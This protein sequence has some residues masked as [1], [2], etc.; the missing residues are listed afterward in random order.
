M[1]ISHEEKVEKI[2]NQLKSYKS[3]EPISL[4]KKSV[5]HQV[6]KPQDKFYSDN[7]I[8]IGDLDE[9][10]SIDPDE[11]TCIAEPGVMFVDL[12]KATLKYNLVPLTVPEHKT[13][14]IGGAVAGCSIE[15]MSYKYGGFHDSCLE[16]EVITA[17]G[18]VII[19]S[20]KDNN[21]LFQMMQGTFGTLGIISRLKFKLVQ[22]KPFVKVTHE[23][24]GSL[25]D[26]KS[27]IWKHFK[28]KDIDFMDGFI[29]G[30]EEMMLSIGNFVDKAPYS[31]SYDWTRV[32]Y[33]Q[34]IM[35]RRE[36]YL[37]TK[38]Y[39]FRYDKGHATPTRK[40]FIGRLLFGKFSGSNS[41]LKLANEFHWLIP[42]DKIPIIV[43]LFIPFSKME[44]FMDWYVKQID[45][46]PLWCVPYKPQ[47]NY[48]WLS[49]EFVSKKDDGLVLDIAIYDMKKNKDKNYYRMME[50]ELMKIKG[51]KTLISNNYYFEKEFWKIW[52]KKNYY[53][54]KKI[55][56]PANILRDLYEKTCQASMGLGR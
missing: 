27:A 44:E 29:N 43:D 25:K 40:T 10:I 38:N 8:Y 33:S 13:I 11:K 30:T 54:I 46:F 34:S 24:Y 1:V 45:F 39:L 14:T 37:K 21:L 7:K 6:P 17:K 18:D 3:K 9:I 23:K 55:T 5:P 2:S 15:S 36:D 16:Y 41:I 31:H 52:N 51:I 35:K 49:P 56:D 12:V 28:N 42:P 4:K 20:P 26:Y 32:Y 22:A 48:E 53:K 50:Q 19:C 47:H